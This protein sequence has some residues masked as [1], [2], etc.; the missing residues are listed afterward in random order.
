MFLHWNL[1]QMEQHPIPPGNLEEQKDFDLQLEED[2]LQTLSKMVNWKEITKTNYP[3]PFIP[4]TSL[5]FERPK[6]LMDFSPIPL[7]K[8]FFDEGIWEYF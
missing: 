6:D 4:K 8:A 3:T 5:P 7:F 1:S 2:L